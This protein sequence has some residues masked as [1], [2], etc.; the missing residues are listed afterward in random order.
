MRLT[1]ATH[2]LK[3]TALEGVTLEGETLDA[4]RAFWDRSAE[5]DSLVAILAD[6][7]SES[8]ETSG[9]R[10]AE[11]LKGF[12]PAGAKVLDI[13]CGT[14]RI[15]RHVSPLAAEVHGVDISKEMCEQGEEQLSDL[16][17]V[18][19]HVGNGYDLGDFEDDSLDL[20]YSVVAL[21]HM[22]RPIAFNY[23]RESFR[24]LKPGGTLWFYVPNLLSD[25]DFAGFNHLA[26]PYF[27]SNPYPMNFFTPAE[28]ARL[29]TVAG[30]RLESLTEEMRAEA[31]KTGEPGLSMEVEA[32]IGAPADRERLVAEVHK[33]TAERDR[34][35]ERNAHL[36]QQLDRIRSQPVIKL[37]AAARRKL[38]R[39]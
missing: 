9:R 16:P 24:V 19:F 11:L 26:Q 1:D 28:V 13:G 20:V 39:S 4:H 8:F 14:G 36:T 7:D 29:V 35:A 33:V 17:N 15:M 18:H 31:R 37:A 12:L 34:L 10:E 32:M 25:G 6:G 30:F 5:V 23:L 27:V 21:Q 38:R 22:P 2:G 3:R